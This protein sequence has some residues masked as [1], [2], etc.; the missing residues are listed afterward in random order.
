LGVRND[1]DKKSHSNSFSILA[2][3]ITIARCDPKLALRIPD[4]FEMHPGDTRS[5]NPRIPVPTVLAFPASNNGSTA[6][7]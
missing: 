7:H 4:L 3:P 6:R 5:A 1:I 2:H